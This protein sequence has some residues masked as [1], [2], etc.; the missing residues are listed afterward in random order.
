MTSPSNDPL[1]F[2]YPIVEPDSS[3]MLDVSGGHSIWWEASGHCDGVPVL[4]LHGGPGAPARPRHRRFYDPDFYRL[5]VM[6][7]RGCGNS[8]PLAEV[9]GNT[10]QALIADIELLRALVG[11]E[12]WLVSGGSWGSKLALAYGERYPERC[13]GFSLGG[14]TLG[15]PH[16][17]DWWWGGAGM[18]F[19]EAHDGLIEAL[20]PNLRGDPLRG[21]H[22]LLLDPDP[23]VHLAA[24]KALCL[25]SAAT[26]NVAPSPELAASYDDPEVAL[27]LARL[28]VHYAFNGF[29][30][31]P[32][33]ILTNL[34]RVSHLPCELVAGR[35]DV[36]TPCEAAWTLHKAW[37]GSNLTIVADGAHGIADPSSAAATLAA[38]ERMKEWIS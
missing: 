1:H 4:F 2:L 11:V 34:H 20:P 18:L 22:Y 26:V 14:I 25:Y 32:D 30:L 17:I 21:Y 3:G 5:I 27:P 24:A 15:R 35:Y 36:T 9:A 29:F 16:E 38:N 33:E 6:H 7:Q 23:T 8:R 10:T 19:P 37:P 13:L 28:F 12:R 31:A